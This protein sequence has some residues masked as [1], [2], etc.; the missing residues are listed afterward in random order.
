MYSNPVFDALKLPSQAKEKRAAEY[1][2]VST[3]R[4]QYSIEN[5]SA[6]IRLY[7]AQRGLKIV[8]TYVDYGKSGLRV[9]GR[10]ALQTL[11]HDVE[12]KRAE[13][14]TI[15]VYDM[16]RWGRFQDSDE[17]AYY[18][19][20]CRRSGV[21]VTFCAEPFEE[22]DSF[23]YGLVK[24]LRRAM[25][26]EYSRNLSVRVWNGQCRLAGM[27]FKQGGPAGFG[28]RRLLLD[29]AG[30]PKFILK[31]GERKGLYTD[32]VIL[33]PG[34]RE[35]I[36]IV[37]RI[38]DLYAFEDKS[39][40]Q[41]S[42]ILNADPLRPASSPTW[43][44]RWIHGVL[45]GHK[46]TGANV[47]NR[48]SSRLTT[49]QTRNPKKDWVHCDRAF[50][51][52][53][54]PELFDFV[55]AK[56]N[57]TPNKYEIP[58]M[59]RKL[60][61]LLLKKGELSAALIRAEPGMPTAA[62]YWLR[63]GGLREAYAAVGYCRTKNINYIENKKTVARLRS[64]LIGDLIVGFQNSGA[65]V[66]WSEETNMLTIN[67]TWTLSINLLRC[68]VR[69]VNDLMW[70]VTIQSKLSGDMVLACRLG[71]GNE[72]IRDFFVIPKPAL[73]GIPKC[74]TKGAKRMSAFKISSL[75]DL[76]CCNPPQ[77]AP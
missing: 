68:F 12:S 70:R 28:L 76:Y 74:I 62:T 53:V 29:S 13:F 46:Y 44:K 42:E 41:I 25:A 47:Y 30:V 1:L 26:A 49:H 69:K 27:G 40:K 60:H 10:A 18:D 52:L 71:P 43:T 57:W 11:L 66:A 33:I 45:S 14:S 20:I 16:S 51:A 50:R 9:E 77:I 55:Q 37:W 21:R 8:R 32:R 17:S 2:R 59:R 63:F 4:Q 65:A 61:E 3:E 58:Y 39:E 7:A 67:D 19:H 36:E 73:E 48:L 54:T 34:P 24:N 35:E 5:Q 56:F 15:L 23:M 64:N 22:D 38:F 6:A 75:D 31:F 72:S